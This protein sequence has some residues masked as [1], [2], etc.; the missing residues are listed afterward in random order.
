MSSFS[1]D[2]ARILGNK[3]I[4]GHFRKFEAKQNVGREKM[5]G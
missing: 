5:G 4:P 1:T 2:F 3:K